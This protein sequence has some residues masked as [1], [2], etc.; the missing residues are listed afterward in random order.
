MLLLRACARSYE[1]RSRP[2][3]GSGLSCSFTPLHTAQMGHWADDLVPEVKQRLGITGDEQD[4]KVLAAARI[5]E[6]EIELLAG[7]QFIFHHATLRFDSGELPFVPVPDLQ[8]DSMQA[9]AECW[10]I[11]DPVQPQRS[12]ILQVRR[13]LEPPLRAVPK[14]EALSAAGTALAALHRE[15]WL[16]LAPRV[17]FQYQ[18]KAEGEVEFGRR[19][20]DPNRY[21]VAP[22]IAGEVEGWVVQVSRRI[23]LMT[24]ET[25][26]DPGLVEQLA[27]V[28]DG[29]AVVAG[30]PILIVARCWRQDYLHTD[31]QDWARPGWQRR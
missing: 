22:V 2:G 27:P 11:P 20:L 3:N 15:G 30:E 10:P 4:A 19:L 23:Q 7:R 25:P 5:A 28:Q 14:A 24:Q 17:W 13:A 26:G 8:I 29:M 6:S 16:S 18:T 1:T 21:V 12:S 31:R 9:T